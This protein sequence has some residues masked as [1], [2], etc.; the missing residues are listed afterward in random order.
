MLRTLLI[1]ATL[2]VGACESATT[3]EGCP[4]MISEL[5]RAHMEACIAAYHAE[6]ARLEGRAVTTCRTIGSTTSCVSE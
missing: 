3:S 2:A 6:K 1:V 4:V 5:G